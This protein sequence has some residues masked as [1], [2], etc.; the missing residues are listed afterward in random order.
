MMARGIGHVVVRRENDEAL[1]SQEWA[2]AVE[3]LLGCLCARCAVMIRQA[4]RRDAEVGAAGDP[5]KRRHAGKRGQID[6]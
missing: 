2:I 5:L 1:E 6:G 4:F 3:T